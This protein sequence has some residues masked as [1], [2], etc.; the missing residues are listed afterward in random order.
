MSCKI[1]IVARINGRSFKAE[2]SEEVC[3]VLA[4]VYPED[5][6]TAVA[7]LA[8]KHAAQLKR[9]GNW[10]RRLINEALSG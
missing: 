10:V 9:L 5:P 1:E 4:E 8:E 2:L 7:T 6:A 3:E